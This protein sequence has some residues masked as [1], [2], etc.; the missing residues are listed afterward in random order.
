MLIVAPKVMLK[1]ITPR[2]V[3]FIEEAGR[4]AYRSE[5]QGSPD[6]FIM[7][8][9][10]RGHLSVLEHASASIEFVTD[11]GITHE[12]VRHRLCAFTQ[13]STRYCNYGDEAIKFIVPP[14]LEGENYHIWQT[15]CLEAEANYKGLLKGGCSPQIARAVLPNCLATKIILTAN[16][17]EWRHIF[18]LRCA[19]PA[20]PQ[21][22]EIMLIALHLLHDEVN[23]VFDDQ[24]NEFIEKERK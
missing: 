22:R 13:E 23:C 16:L 24:Y 15:A 8:L 3:H 14:T 7:M 21:I 12:M 2:A 11:R 18:S 10:R 5:P 19:K 9:I 17:R 1:S 20:H 6:K 4:V